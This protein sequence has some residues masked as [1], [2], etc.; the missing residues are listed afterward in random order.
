MNIPLF[1]MKDV[2]RILRVQPYQIAYLFNTNRVPEPELRLGNRRIF[3]P[4]DIKRLAA[5]LAVALPDNFEG[6]KENHE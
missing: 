5:K 1:S 2:A 3:A 4:K 6:G